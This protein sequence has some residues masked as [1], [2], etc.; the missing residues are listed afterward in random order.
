[1]APIKIIT[2]HAAK[3]PQKTLPVSQNGLGPGFLR[4]VDPILNAQSKL[5][6]QSQLLIAGVIAH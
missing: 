6:L 4:I 3:R 5:L 1:M 2:E